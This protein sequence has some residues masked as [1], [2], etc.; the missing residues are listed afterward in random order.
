MKIASREKKLLRMAN[1]AKLRSFNTTPRFKYGFE[2]PRNYHHAVLLDNR[3]GNTKWQDAAKLE[4][5]QLDEYSTFEDYGDSNTSA[6]PAGYKKMRI[7]LVFDVKHDGQ[8]KVRFVADGHLTEIPLDSAVRI[9]LF[10]AKLNKVNV[11][12]TNIGNAYLE[13]ETKERIYIIARSK[14]RSRKGRILIIRALYGLRS[15]GKRWHEQFADCLR[16]RGFTPCKQN[17]MSGY[18]LTRNNRATKWLP[19]MWMISP[20]V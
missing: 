7:H 15:S 16:D 17:Q 13:A 10:L 4:F 18:D 3:N 8:H 12:A 2:I 6:P 19:Y 9:V 20:S 1:Q 14:F 5:D 11:W